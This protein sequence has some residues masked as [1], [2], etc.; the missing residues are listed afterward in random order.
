MIFTL[1]EEES[2]DGEDS[3]NLE[4]YIIKRLKIE[5]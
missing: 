5:I 4:D 1:F 3:D 2:R